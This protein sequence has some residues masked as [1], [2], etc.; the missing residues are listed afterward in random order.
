MV[1]LYGFHVGKYT[2]TM[3]DMGN[4]S[5]H[6]GWMFLGSII[7]AFCCWPS[8]AGAKKSPPMS[9]QGSWKMGPNENNWVVVSNICYF[10]PYLGK[11]I[12]I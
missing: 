9:E 1:D 3:D 8:R 2:G 7:G 6:S 4:I 5:V 10:H 11:M 12:P